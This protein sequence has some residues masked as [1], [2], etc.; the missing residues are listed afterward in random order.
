MLK[1]AAAGGVPAETRPGRIGEPQ[2]AASE[3][4]ASYAFDLKQDGLV[5]LSGTIPAGWSEQPGTW[6]ISED[7]G[8]LAWLKFLAVDAGKPVSFSE[9]VPLKA[10]AYRWYVPSGSSTAA[11]LGKD[12]AR[13]GLLLRRGQDELLIERHRGADGKLPPLRAELMGQLAELLALERSRKEV[14]DSQRLREEEERQQL[15]RLAQEKERI[16]REE[17]KRMEHELQSLADEQQRLK[18]EQRR[19]EQELRARDAAAKAKGAEEEDK[20]RAERARLFEEQRRN[21]AELEQAQRQQQEQAERS[22]AELARLKAEQLELQA[23]QEVEAMVAKLETER[24]REELLR[25]EA[26]RL[27]AEEARLRA[28]EADFK[29]LVDELTAA[30]LIDKAGPYKVEL[31]ARVLAVNGKRQPADVHERIK[32]FYEDRFKKKLPDDGPVTIMNKK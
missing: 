4:F 19:M 28:Q 7:D 29:A 8:G 10:G 14:S 16:K 17:K 22:R 13:T 26:E 20:L 32:K 18:E 24:A 11:R 30:G 23:R 31:S 2:A 25:R 27:K 3:K 6:I 1:L 15:L 12:A 9:E 5:G 21:A